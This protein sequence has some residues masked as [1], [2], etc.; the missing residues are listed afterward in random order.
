MPYV[1]DGHCGS[2]PQMRIAEQDLLEFKGLDDDEE[3][4]GR[5]GPGCKL[6]GLPRG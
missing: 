2:G 1:A 4:R 5:V 6:R 3:V